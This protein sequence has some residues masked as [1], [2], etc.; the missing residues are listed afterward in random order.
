MNQQE[1]TI[2]KFIHLSDIHLLGTPSDKLYGIKPSKRFKRALKNI[3]AHHSDAD[4]V[5]IT[6]DLTNNADPGAYAQL[7]K[8]I[9]GLGIPVY[10]LMGNHDHR[11]TFWKFFPEFR[12]GNFVQYVRE[13]DNR[14][15]LF[16]DTLVE[17]EEYGLLCEERLA[18]LEKQLKRYADRKVYLLMHHHPIRSGLYRMD[19]VGNFR[20]AKAFWKLLSRYDSVQH[21]FFGHLHRPM[22]AFHRSVS[23]S[24]TRSTTFQVAYRP[25][26]TAEHLTT[27]V[28]PA[29]SVV[30]LDEE[31]MAIHLCEY[32]GEY[33]VSRVED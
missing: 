22:Q 30:K 32:L 24:A 18:W 21:I 33:G 29:Y 4:C 19:T 14:V 10:P 31:D 11:K 2:M 5:V 12:D 8:Q 9:D 20:S 28:Q 6:G 16:L 15:F 27:S 7:K 26:E 1:K 23:L 17:G 13:F 3:R 25:D